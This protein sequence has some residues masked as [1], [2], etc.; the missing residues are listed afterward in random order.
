MQIVKTLLGTDT[1]SDVDTLRTRH[2][3]AAR[4]VAQGA[5]EIE[6]LTTSAARLRLARARLLEQRDDD[7]GIDLHV[8]LRKV[9]GELATVQRRLD[10]LADIQR[11]REE[12]VATLAAAVRAAEQAAAPA[13]MRNLVRDHGRDREALRTA[14]TDIQDL[15][16]KILSGES[17]MQ[18]LYHQHGVKAENVLIIEALATTARDT[19]ADIIGK[20]TWQD[21][22]VQR[23][24]ELAAKLEQDRAEV[25]RRNQAAGVPGLWRAPGADFFQNGWVAESVEERDARANG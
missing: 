1:T 25:D 2:G 12:N 6:T 13:R 7:P 10:D 9:E 22:Q 24:D 17:D 3:D 5:T 16:G 18:A 4:K 19:A 23:G 8:P 20:L 15:A 14:M 21:A 11:V